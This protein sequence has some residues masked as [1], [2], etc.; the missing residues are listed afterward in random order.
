MGNLSHSLRRDMWNKFHEEKITQGIFWILQYKR[1]AH[2]P[3]ISF[4]D[5][6]AKL[7]NHEIQ[8]HTKHNRCLNLQLLEQNQ[9]TYFKNWK[10][11]NFAS[12][13]NLGICML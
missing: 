6:T 4:V 2:S 13:E 9:L 7:T 11:D 8:H 12:F 1:L 3:F 10:R 5:I